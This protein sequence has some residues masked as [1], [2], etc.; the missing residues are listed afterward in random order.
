MKDIFLDE[1]NIILFK[2]QIILKNIFR[3]KYY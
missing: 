3:K 1:K 2:K